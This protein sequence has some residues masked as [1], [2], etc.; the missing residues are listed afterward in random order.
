MNHD[1]QTFGTV[2]DFLE[3]YADNHTKPM[4]EG[5]ELLADVADYLMEYPG[6]S[7]LDYHSRVICQQ[8]IANHLGEDHKI[9]AVWV[10]FLHACV[11]KIE[12]HGQQF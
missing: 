12:A 1:T 3:D 10:R 7:A 4:D 2:L 5:Q 9:G 6:A 8:L 11:Q